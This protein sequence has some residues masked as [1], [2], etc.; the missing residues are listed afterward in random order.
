M[1]KWKRDIKK[2]A[3]IQI[4]VFFFILSG[5]AGQQQ[6]KPEVPYVPTPENVVAEMLRLAEVTKDDVL[7]DLGCGDGRIVITAAAQLGCRGVWESI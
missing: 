3:I 1:G 6:K 7:Y 2:V 5:S 4:L